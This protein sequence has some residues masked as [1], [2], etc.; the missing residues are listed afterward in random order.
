MNL[1][2]ERVVKKI[3]KQ[4][5]L[6]PAQRLGQNFLIARKVLKKIVQAAN[7]S[8][9]DTV[10][11]VGPGLG[12][13]TQ[14]LAQ[15]AKE[16]IAVEKD[17][18]MGKILEE[19]LKG[20]ENVEVVRGDILHLLNSKLKA[21]SSKPPLKTKNYKIVA[22]LPFYLTAR[23]IRKFL[24]NS[25]APSEMILVVQKEVAQ[26]LCPPPLK[27]RRASVKPPRMNLL[28]IAVRFYA[29]PKII[30]PVPKT[31]FW[32][33]PEVDAAIVKF[34]VRSLKFKVERELFFNIVRAGFAQPR[35]KLINNLSSRLAVNKKEVRQ[36]LKRCK[37]E[38]DAR[39]ENLTLK[40]WLLLTNSPPFRQ[41]LGR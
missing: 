19:T 12:T 32:P 7:L 3:L 10:L 35:K 38:Q 21:R 4:H 34:R 24:E 1:C 20:L 13:I 41:H 25:K 16:V 9:R 22:N 17:P 18:R 37:I 28:A 11:E 5:N 14:E 26:R 33:R 8:P 27:L 2:S 31:A 6:K 15:K 36:W 40:E 23:L 30:A 29:E 39:A